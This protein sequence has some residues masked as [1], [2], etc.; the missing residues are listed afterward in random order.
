MVRTD[1]A[2][3][4]VRSREF[5]PPPLAREAQPDQSADGRRRRLAM[6]AATARPESSS[7]QPE[8]LGIRSVWNITCGEFE[9]AARSAS[10]FRTAPSNVRFRLEIPRMGI[11]GS[12]RGNA[13]KDSLAMRSGKLRGVGLRFVPAGSSTMSASAYEADR[14]DVNREAWLA[15]VP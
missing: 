5:A 10:G 6:N 9:P 2:Y 4:F 1:H 13:D 14:E 3:P 12:M 7:A 11:A 8:G 15:G